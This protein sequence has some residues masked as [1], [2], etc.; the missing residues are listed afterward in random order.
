MQQGDSTV[1]QIEILDNTHVI[2]TFVKIEYS[3]SINVSGKG[4]V[5]KSPEQAFYYYGDVVEL[6]AQASPGW[7]FEN[8]SGDLTGTNP[9]K[10]IT[11]NSDKHIIANFEEEK[12]TLT[13]DIFGDGSVLIDP[14]KNEYEY[15]E[16]VELTPLASAGWYFSE[17]AGDQSGD[18]HPIIIKMNKNKEII[19]FFEE[20]IIL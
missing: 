4:E 17:W 14:E 3:I 2:A 8:W 19:A 15:G 11:V 12:Y 20:I 10:E 6:T 5:S 9:V 16:Y 18:T 7:E 13:I 1:I